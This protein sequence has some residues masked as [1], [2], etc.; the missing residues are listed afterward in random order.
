MSYHLDTK[1]DV[2]IAFLSDLGFESFVEEENKT[3]AYLNKSIYE[4][5]AP[6]AAEILKNF[7]IAYSVTEVEPQNW[8]SIWEESFQPV[9]V[10]EFCLVR[11]DFH[12]ANTSV[13]HD[14]II[15]P[16]MAFGTGH[17]ATTYLMMEHMQFI[18]FK[19]KRVLDYGAGTGI[20]AILASKLGCSS[21]DAVDIEW[22]SF[23]NIQENANIN[24]ALNIKAIHGTLDHINPAE[25]YH[26]ILANI[27]RNI[28]ILSCERLF[29][30]LIPKG[31]LLISGI[32][33]EDVR[34]VNQVFVETGFCTT[35]IKNLNG[36]SCITYSKD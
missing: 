16:K 18:N 8:N 35:Q 4:A 36:W 20:L 33:E 7:H 31:K 10:G 23:Q 12:E 25:P 1:D 27:N 22:E 32:L 17:H 29:Q 2:V 19:T 30:L 11:A 9:Q 13:T 21:V 34:Q 14:I 28:L 6:A 15:N 5:V 24:K 3:I 26:I